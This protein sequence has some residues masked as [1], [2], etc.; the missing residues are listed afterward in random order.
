MEIKKALIELNLYKKTK[1]RMAYI[2][3]RS[4][5]LQDRI[6]SLGGASENLGVQG[7]QASKEDKIVSLMDKIKQ[8]RDELFELET[9]SLCVQNDIERKIYRLREP[10]CS[11]LRGYYCQAK[12]LEVLAVEMNYSF[13]GVKQIKRRGIKLYSTL[14]P[15][16]DITYYQDS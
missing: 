4:V 10:Y 9:Y 3:E 14:P 16:Y 13:D 11:V 1:K 8:Y 15:L 5:E 7:G 6:Y 12:R 2:K